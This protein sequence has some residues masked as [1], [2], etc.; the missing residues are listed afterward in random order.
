MH[1]ELQKVNLKLKSHEENLELLI[2][3]RTSQ[4]TIID[5]FQTQFIVQTDPFEMYDRLRDD[6]LSLTG[7]SIGFIGEVLEQ[8]DGSPMLKIY[9]LS[10]IA[11]DK[12]T[13]ELYNTYQ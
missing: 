2:K 10:N 13:N 8:E 7:S 9:S 3:E 11:W 12:A 4:L 5:D 1:L 6:L